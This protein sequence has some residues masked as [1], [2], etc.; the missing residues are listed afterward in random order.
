MGKDGRFDPVKLPAGALETIFPSITEDAAGEI[1]VATSRG[2]GRVRDGVFLP[3][4][5]GSGSFVDRDAQRR[6]WIAAPGRLVRR[7]GAQEKRA[8]T[9]VDGQPGN[10]RLIPGANVRIGPDG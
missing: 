8:E 5:E 4:V 1:W 9:V 6:I 7:R 2:T 10:H 3:E